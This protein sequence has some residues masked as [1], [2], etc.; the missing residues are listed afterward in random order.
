MDF[1]GG[2]MKFKPIYIYL[3]LLVAAITVLV[4]FT[5]KEQSGTDTDDIVNKQMPMDDV[6]KNLNMPGN[7]PGRENVSE[8]FK[9]KLETLKKAYEQN[10][11][12]TLMMRE[13]ADFQMAAHNHAEALILYQ[14]ILDK[15][16]KRTDIIFTIASIYYEQKNFS[17]CEEII[18]RV[19]TYDKNNLEARYNIGVIAAASGDREKAKLIWQKISD[20]NPNTPMGI[21]AKSSLEQL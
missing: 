6:H 8:S 14:K 4:F 9:Q 5:Q 7:Q 18:N 2:K 11:S 1:L 3:L 21:K 20:E 16:P 12:D 10:P 19:F 15:N 17:K 13:Y